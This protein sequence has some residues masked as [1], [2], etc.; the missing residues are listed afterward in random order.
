[1]HHVANSIS[2]MS[3]SGF[4]LFPVFL[5]IGPI[6]S[7]VTAGL[8]GKL[9][10]SWCKWTMSI[11]P[12]LTKRTRWSAKD[13]SDCCAWQLL[14]KLAFSL[15]HLFLF[16]VDI[17]FKKTKIIKTSNVQKTYIVH[18]YTSAFSWMSD[19]MFSPTRNV[20]F[21]P[22]IAAVDERNRFFEIENKGKI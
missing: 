8:K 11:C 7:W 1:M 18:T 3:I 16:E 10:S 17:L 6:C 19:W 20:V 4:C 22:L 12:W 2:C 14:Q 15:L 21:V 13:I 5:G 9:R